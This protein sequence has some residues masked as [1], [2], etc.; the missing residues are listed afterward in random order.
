MIKTVL[1]I[2]IILL[3]ILYIRN[4]NQENLFYD[5]NTYHSLQTQE[6][7]LNKLQNQYDDK[8]PDEDIITNLTDCRANLVY[9]M[10]F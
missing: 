3:I 7:I 9:K 2:C 6:K 1:I 4:N 8:I 5:E 10:N